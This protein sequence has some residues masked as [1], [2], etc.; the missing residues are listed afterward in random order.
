MERETEEEREKEIGQSY[1]IESKI[2]IAINGKRK[3][4]E[5]KKHK[6]K[7]IIVMMVKCQVRYM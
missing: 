2:C 1:R 3:E 7:L 6:Q 5:K 4:E